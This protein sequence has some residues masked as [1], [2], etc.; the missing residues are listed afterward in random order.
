VGLVYTLDLPLQLPR[1]CTP[2]GVC[3]SPPFGGG[4]TVDSI[5]VTGIS[6]TTPAAPSGHVL[7]VWQVSGGIASCYVPTASGGTPGG[8]TGSPQINAGGG[9]FGAIP[10]SDYGVTSGGVL[11]LGYPTTGG[12]IDV[13]ITDPAADSQP[14]NVNLGPQPVSSNFHSAQFTMGSNESSP[15]TGNLQCNTSDNCLR[16]DNWSATGTGQVAGFYADNATPS[17]NGGDSINVG[18][19]TL[20]YDYLG[21][22]FNFQG[23]SSPWNNGQLYVIG[24]P[25]AAK[26]DGLG[27]FYTPELATVASPSPVCPNGP[28]G[29]YSL[30]CVVTVPAQALFGTGA[31]TAGAQIVQ[32]PAQTYSTGAIT[33]G[34]NV[35]SGNLLVVS[36]QSWGAG[37]GSTLHDSLGTVF[38]LVGSQTSSVYNVYVF[39]G[40]ATASGADTITV[41]PADTGRDI[42]SAMEVSGTT[43]TVD[44]EVSVNNTGANPFALNLTTTH[45]NDFIF[46]ASGS[47]C[48]FCVTGIQF[49]PPYSTNQ[50]TNSGFGGAIGTAF[51]GPAGSYPLTVAASFVSSSPPVTPA[52]QPAVIVA[53][54][55]NAPYATTGMVYY[56]QSASPYA[57]YVFNAGWH[58]F[59]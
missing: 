23:A 38:S 57:A 18:I 14:F 19:A 39:A 16:V 28:N 27:N 26:F 29:A 32:N 44:A 25:A 8:G 13:N 3:Y 41:S 49:Q 40:L 53:F 56:D 24:G 10:N 31:P 48:Y 2:A 15:G 12:G 5:A 11:T 33:F 58:A 4:I 9:N 43:A 34:S 46:A 21:L 42:M 51:S 20:N 37:S 1:I 30:N 50:F 35:T 6:S 55:A 36:Y 54:E 22:Y 59:N 45:T 47:V 17:T 7:C 52:N